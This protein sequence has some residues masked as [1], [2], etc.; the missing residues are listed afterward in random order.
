MENI[1]P[2]IDLSGKTV[3]VT[4]AGRG[5]GKHIALLA[6]KAGA[7][8]AITYA[9]SAAP[10]Q[11]VVDEIKA[12]GRNAM[13]YQADAA[14]AARAGEVIDD[15]VKQWGKL[16]VLVNNAGITRDTLV[17]RMSETQWD[18]VIRTN[19]TSVFNYCK[20]ATR[21]MMKQREGSIVNIS[22]VVGISGNA[23]Q[24]NYAASKAGM[25]GFSKSLA[26]ELASR[27]V[28]VNVVAPGYITTDMTDGLPEAVLAKIS[29]DTPLG[30]SGKSDEVAAAVVFLASPAASFITGEVLK[31]D[32]GMAM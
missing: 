18:E 16:D 32:G 19:L 10:A 3:L 23:G 26:K 14:D 20:A 13:A 22:S 7:D 28:R 15:L 2:I 27:N 24:T 8:V 11:T 31:V 1:M 12:M 17:M 4:G 21:P 5:I 6:A 25:I 29:E 30:R 9:S